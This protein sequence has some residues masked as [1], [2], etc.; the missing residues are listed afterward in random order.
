MRAQKSLGSK[1][2]KS[3]SLSV[4]HRDKKRPRP[5]LFCLRVV[6]HAIECAKG[7]IRQAKPMASTLS[8]KMRTSPR[9]RVEW[10]GTDDVDFASHLE[11]YERE[12]CLDEATS[13][14]NRGIP[15]VWLSELG[16][17]DTK[18]YSTEYDWLY[19]WWSVAAQRGNS[20]ELPVGGEG[21]PRKK[22]WRYHAFYK[23]LDDAIREQEARKAKKRRLSRTSKPVFPVFRDQS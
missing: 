20:G 9:F 16:A 8:A 21:V 7:R 13:L 4:I 2:N 3:S 10:S 22:S 18:G 14:V 1:W 11:F 15:F 23:P 19:F 5:C 6:R 12:R 17:Y